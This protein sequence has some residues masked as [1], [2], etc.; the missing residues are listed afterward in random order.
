MEFRFSA[1]EKLFRERVR[2][3]LAESAPKGQRPPRGHAMRDFDL[4]WQRAKFEG[5]FGAISWPK[6]YGGANLSPVE[7]MIWYEEVARARAPTLGCLSIA[8]NHAGPTVMALGTPEQRAFHLP[9][10]LRGE[11]VWCQGFSEPGAGSDLAGLR[12]RAEVDG[13]HLVI[14]GQKVWT[15]H[16][17]YAD[18]QETLVRTD[19]SLGRHKGI[20]WVI[21]DMT[22]PGIT[23]RPLRT[24]AG[25][26]HF[27]EVFYDNVRVPLSNVVGELNEGWKVAM[28]TLANERAGATA[29]HG[30]ELGE[31][32]E[33]LIELARSSIHSSSVDDAFVSRLARLR[34]DAAALRSLS[35]AMISRANRGLPVGVEATLPFLFFGELQQRVRAL[36]AELL[37]GEMLEIDGPWDSWVRGFF[38]DR[39]YV[40]AGGSSEVRRNIIAE[41]ILGL[42]RSY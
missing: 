30:A 38:A 13:D 29:N 19:P 23:V 34:T 27:N 4:A 7:Q 8:I 18:Y 39:M 40:I 31:L 24:I 11:V 36:A 21:I 2:D 16:A 25:D 3:W 17:Q 41:R 12:M 28:T 5:G 14:N 9:K 37:G 42:P 35:Y 26:E 32:V 22:T 20:T 1:S 10:I 15:S 33:Q 6:E